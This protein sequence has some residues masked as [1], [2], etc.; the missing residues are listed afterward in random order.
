ME[1]MLSQCKL[2]IYTI[3]PNS[4][5]S[6]CIENREMMVKNKKIKINQIS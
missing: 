1:E 4:L 2:H 6:F 3:V 5:Y